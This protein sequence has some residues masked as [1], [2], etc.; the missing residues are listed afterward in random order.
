MGFEQAWFAMD[1]GLII[2]HLTRPARRK[3]HVIRGC[4]L[5]GSAAV[6]MPDE[7][8]LLPGARQSPSAAVARGIPGNE[9]NSS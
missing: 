5:Q 9:R 1:S 4:S 6:E 7:Y 8:R 2:A 3:E